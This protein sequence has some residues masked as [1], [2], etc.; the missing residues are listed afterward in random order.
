MLKYL[1]AVCALG[2]SQVNALSS[3]VKLDVGQGIFSTELKLGAAL[4]SN[5]DKLTSQKPSGSLSVGAV[6][7][8]DQNIFIGLLAGA[9]YN[10]AQ[11]SLQNVSY[12]Y[13]GNIVSR[14]QTI[15]LKETAH[16]GIILGVVSSAGVELYVLPKYTMAKVDVDVQSLG[17]SKLTQKGWGIEA[18]LIAAVSDSI[19][20]GLSYSMS[21]LGKYSW[22]HT[23]NILATEMYDLNNVSL[24]TVVSF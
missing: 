16:A 22:T 2:L 9:G 19:S 4:G 3:F 24:T 15:T 23:G 7:M 18:G 17:L 11:S 21:S 14:A 8:I 12:N 20:M 5:V 1:A 13:L 6:E 10:Q